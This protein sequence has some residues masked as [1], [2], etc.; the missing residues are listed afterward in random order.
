MASQNGHSSDLEATTYERIMGFDND[1]ALSA[2]SHRL[3]SFRQW[4]VDDAHASVSPALCIVNGRATDGTKNAP[5]LVMDKPAHASSSQTN[6]SQATTTSGKAKPPNNADRRLGVIDTDADQT[7]Y[8]RTMGC[9]VRV[10]RAIEKDE[11]LFRVPRTAFVTPDLV[12]ASDAG[13]AV[14]ACC[15]RRP[16]TALEERTTSSYWDVLENTTV[17]ENK[18]M[19]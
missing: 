19:P 6:N 15:Q 5:V 2:L 14:L 11:V 16:T 4:L 17:C 12:A 9:Q 1:D 10:A 18:F 3:V 8:D 13:R 7:L